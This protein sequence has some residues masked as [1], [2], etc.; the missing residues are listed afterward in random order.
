MKNIGSGFGDYSDL[1]KR[2]GVEQIKARY[3]FLYEE[4]NIFFDSFGRND[5]REILKI[6][7]RSLMHCVLEYFEDIEK[8]KSAHNLDHTNSPKVMAYTAYWFLRRH[9]IQISD[10]AE[11]DDDLVFANEKFVLSMLI[12]FLTMGAESKALIGDDKDI[13][14]AFVNSF[15]YFLKFRRLD[16]QAIE[17]VLLSFRLGGVYPECKAIQ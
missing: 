9:P 14:I 10:L 4:V 1:V 12:S 7:E 17:M 11:E 8:V 13:Y 15:F 2:I 16:P 3:E 5:I 6:N